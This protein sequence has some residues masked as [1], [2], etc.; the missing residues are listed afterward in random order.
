ML[1]SSVPVTLANHRARACGVERGAWRAV[2]RA[3][4]QAFRW[5]LPLAL[6]VLL[7]GEASANGAV[8]LASGVE[9]AEC[10]LADFSAAGQGS[11]SV[12]GEPELEP[13]VDAGVEV[14]LPA[15]AAAPREAD[16]TAAPMC[17][18]TAASVA[19][20]IEVPEVDRG[21]LEPLPCDAER[22]LALLSSGVRAAGECFIAAG[23]PTPQ[24]RLPSLQL[25]AARPE[26]TAPFLAL[27]PA[28]SASTPL[29]ADRRRGLAWQPGHPSPI[30][31]P[32]TL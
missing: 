24:P 8:A 4:W 2:H 19:A 23:D 26:A 3:A 13:G 10:E 12:P 22:W 7:T 15:G 16:D 5:C 31:R 30:F 9:V 29:P 27:F 21:R 18:R 14:A 28:R 6:L 32:P 17:D 11:C 20:V 1:R 25:R